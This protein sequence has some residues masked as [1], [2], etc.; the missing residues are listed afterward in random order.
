MQTNPIIT[1]T[2]TLKTRLKDISDSPY[3]AVDTEFIRDIYYYPKL[4]LIQVA[5][6]D[7]SFILDPISSLDLSPF[8]EILENPDVTKVFHAGRQDIEIFYYVTGL[9][10]RSVFDTQI[11]GMV[12]GFGDSVSYEKLVQELLDKKL[13]KSQRFTH[14]DHRPLSSRQI[15]YALADVHY[16]CEIYEIFSKQLKE[17]NR[18]HWIEEEMATLLNPKTYDRSPESAWERFRAIRS[19]KYENKSEQFFRVARELI[20]WRE[21]KAQKHNRPKRAIFSDETLLELAELAPTASPDLAR[22]RYVK[23]LSEKDKTELFDVIMGA[24]ESDLKVKNQDKSGFRKRYYGSDAVKDL[25]RALLKSKAEEYKVAE[26]LIADLSTI[27]R[28]AMIP[29]AEIKEDDF[30]FLHG[31]RKEVFGND[32][33]KL[34]NTKISLGIKKDEIVVLGT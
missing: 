31:W 15:E 17:K 19:S 11:A 20:I 26:R 6:K 29:I 3:I 1:D 32:A 13:D 21:D 27:E 12:L 30:S 33:L 4:C 5:T 7:T 28:F 24:K 16:L 14:W 2:K 10:P 23:H 25:F 34:K 8:L 22:V 18:E 9:V